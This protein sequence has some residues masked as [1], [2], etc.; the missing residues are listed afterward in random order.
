MPASGPFSPLM[1]GQV[2]AHYRILEKIAAGGMGVVFLAEDTRL[3]RRV[4]LKVLPPEFAGDP[5]RLARFERE[6]RA[7]AALNHPYIAAVYDVGTFSGVPFIVQEYLQ[8][9]TLRDFLAG[10]SLPL[11]RGLEMAV[12][13]AEALGAAHAAGIVHR[14]LKPENIFVTKDG[15]VKLLDFGLAKPL[16]LAAARRM[17][18]STTSG[19]G[20]GSETEPGH[21][22]G[23]V[24]YMAPEQ[25]EGQAVDHRAD[26]F[27]F[28]CVLYEMV[29][30]KAP[31]AGRG[32]VETL[33]RIL[34]EK[35]AGI[36][37]VSL[38][39][40]LQQILD[41]CLAKNRAERYQHAGDLAVDLRRLHRNVESGVALV[42]EQGF[43]SGSA[44]R[45]MRL[46]LALP[47]SAPL[48][49]GER[50]AVA[51]SPDGMRVVYA[52][53][54]GA[55]TQLFL[56][57]MDRFEPAPLAGTED[58]TGPFF[59]PDGQWVGFFARGKLKK[60]SLTG[61]V[62]LGLCDAPE[63][64]GA[65]WAP[66][67]T[68]VFTP[69]QA[70][71][72][73]QI[74]ASGGMPQPLTTPELGSGEVTHRWPEVLPGGKAVL[75]TIGMAGSASYEEARIAL[76]RLDTKE[77]RILIERGAH[78]RYIPTGHLVFVRG[79]ALLA[80]PFDLAR[81]EITGPLVPILEGV[82]TETTGAAQWTFS[83][84]GTLAYLP[85]SV[86]GA[87]RTLVWVNRKGAARPLTVP[88]LTFEEPRLSPDG[89]R[90][91]VGVRRATTDL[92]VYDLERGAMTR[93]TFDADNFSP[94][95]TPNGKQVT[96]SSNRAGA[97]N[98]YRMPAQGGGK[99]ERLTTSEFDQVP[100]SW[101]PDGRLLAFTEY[102]PST[103]ADLWILPLKAPRKPR[104][105]LR[106]PFNE[107]GATFSPDGR[108]LAYASDESGQPEV[109]VQRYRGF[110]SR[111]QISTEGGTEPIW[112]RNGRELVFRSGDK[113]M[114]VA[115]KT[116][117]E[118]NVTKPRLLFAGRYVSGGT[119]YLANYDVA[120][121]GERFLMIQ[122]K[123][124]Q[125]VPGQLC[126]VLDWFA[127]LH[128]RI[129]G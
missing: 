97:S 116:K 98:I 91:A 128:R 58:G 96:F 92:W 87:D 27:S 43:L 48:A 65:S 77:R 93:L 10:V 112:A 124:E 69:A 82:M 106:T 60:I 115:L 64:R 61:G 125:A 102:N 5:Q 123:S 121:D 30:G 119:A 35:P 73:W 33:H 100:N 39:P 122:E 16:K 15:H 36:P 120:P 74:S 14:D 78:A 31:F 63:S 80:M 85:G 107:W 114:A 72:L 89:R 56:R 54:R 90:L 59:S 25:V 28:G 55:R 113:V 19:I 52:A 49:V 95:W 70:S 109:Y 47:R 50:P 126:V 18:G 101:S 57:T 67:D 94:I 6:A 104:P 22:L 62:P 83:G 17:D 34:H 117:P 66:D 40:Q 53:K 105:F 37:D 84:T 108:W 29:S 12:Q 79:A 45:T 127:E 42:G 23:T 44:L 20:S 111:C 76:Q 8:G 129:P 86:R 11:K 68:I 1:V 110:G 103:G 51:L 81:L 118:F 3:G 7:A 26:F 21:I 75:F 9:E 32:S 2:V 24:G 71:G 41:K 99:P 46:T 38:P 13:V 4:A 88:P